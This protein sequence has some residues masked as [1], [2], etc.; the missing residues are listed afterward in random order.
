MH[1]TQFNVTGMTCGSCVARVTNAL[2]KIDGVA[3]VNIALAGGQAIVEFDEQVT[4][5]DELQQAVRQAGYDIAATA[6]KKPA[7]AGGCCCR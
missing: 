4:S 1:T 7:S 2:K 3:Q 5:V 6:A